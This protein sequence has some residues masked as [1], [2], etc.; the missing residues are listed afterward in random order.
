M[1]KKFSLQR[2]LILIFSIISL[3]VLVIV[4]PLINKNLMDVI[5]KQMF[6]TLEIAQRG[7]IDYDYNPIEKSSDK[8]IYHL[9]YDVKNNLIIP[10]GNITYTEAKNLSYVFSSYLTD[11]IKDD[12]EKIQRKEE[13]AGTAIYF[14]ITKKDTNTYVISL[15]YSD[16]SANLISA[17]RQQII[18]TLYIT[19]VIIGVVIFLWVSS[20]IKPLKQIRKY[21]EDI[22]ND[23]ESELK[24]NRKDEIGIVSDE[25]IAM[26]EEINRQSKIKEEMI[27]NISHDLKTPI[28][29]IKSYSQSVKDDIYPYGDKNSSM[30]VIIE[31]A[32]RLE[33]KV[34][35]LL[36]MNR[37]EYLISQDCEG[38]SSNMQEIVETVVQNTKAIRTDIQILTD[39]EEVYFDGLAEPWRVAVENIIEN[40]LRYAKTTIDIH[41]NEEDGLTIANDGPCMEEDRLKVL[42][43]PYEMGKGGKF[44]LGLSI[45]AKV[46][47]A[48]GYDVVGENMAEGVI[49][50]I[51]KPKTSNKKGSKK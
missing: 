48:N 32:D 28:A 35:S 31:N 29:L 38:I 17:I 25:L 19:F 20:L 12:K 4:V 9:T 43:K 18:N 2:Q 50:R 30:D 8:Q 10:S 47:S 27:H 34:H 45:V 36:F 40:A 21:I 51:T 7:Y 15:V 42:F 1:L 22:R 13:Y 41:L 44:G 24:I 16:Y 39:L 6:Q 37:V 3:A 33:Q 49:F 26:K 23:E 5:D 11:M 46:V 14:Q